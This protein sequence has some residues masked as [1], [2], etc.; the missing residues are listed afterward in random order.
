MAIE[1]LAPSASATSIGKHRLRSRRE[2]AEVIEI[3]KPLLLALGYLS[4][5]PEPPRPSPW[6]LRAVKAAG[7]RRRGLPGGRP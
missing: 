5:D 2:L 1:R 4:L 7:R 6:N 3:E